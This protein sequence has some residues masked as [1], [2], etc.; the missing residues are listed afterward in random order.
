MEA[1]LQTIVTG[2]GT[3]AIYAI[4]AIGL[5][6]VFKA[7][8]IVNFVQGE[9]MV[10]CAI[11]AAVF[12]ST[13][14][15]LVLVFL[16][17]IPIGVAM[18]LGTEVVVSRFLR[19]P[20]P[21]TAA[22]G[23]IALGTIVQAITLTTTGGRAYSMPEWPGPSFSIMGVEVSSQ[24][25]WNVLLAV[26][27]AFGLKM[28]FDLTKRGMAL[29]AAADDSRTAALYGVS[30]GS[31]TLWT[32]G[33]AG[34][35]GAIGGL[36]LLPVSLMAFNLGLLFT[37][38]GFAAAML[39][40]LGSMQGALVGGLLIGLLESAFATYVSSTYAGVVVFVVLLG[41]LLIRPSGLFREVAVARV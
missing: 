25:F 30:P 20:K 7:T 27:I 33:M 34:A 29:K 1:L 19:R 13:G 23:T 12:T 36:A 26:V 16:V 11:L 8:R 15:P 5:G 6:T 4:I 3:G 22:I 40:G 38:K 28:F 32:F 41:V 14:W 31:T 35:I 9:Y 18:G 21:L 2:L 17:V 10:V 24:T 37:L 39:G